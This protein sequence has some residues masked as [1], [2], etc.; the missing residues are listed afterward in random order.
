M[1]IIVL[2]FCVIDDFCKEF[3]P[4]W[5]QCLLGLSLKQRRRRGEL[6]LVSNK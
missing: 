2:I 3:E 4:W 5:E 6:C 1:D